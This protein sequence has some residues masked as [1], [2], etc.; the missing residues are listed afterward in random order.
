MFM[1]LWYNKIGEAV[2]EVRALQK[3]T[4]TATE[5]GKI[6]YNEETRQKLDN[7]IKRVLSLKIILAW[8]MIGCIEEYTGMTAEEAAEYI[9][10]EPHVSGVPVHTSAPELVHGL[11]TVDKKS[12]EKTV[13]YD[14]CFT[15]RL[16]GCDDNIGLIIN[17]EAQNDFHPGYPLTK[18]GLYYCARMLSAQF[19]RDFTEGDYGNLKKVYSIWICPHAPD[20]RDNT[21]VRYRIR[22]DALLGSPPEEKKENYDLLS[23]IFICFNDRHMAERAN[24]PLSGN[25]AKDVSRLLGVL[26]S[27]EVESPDKRRIV[28]KEYHMPLTKTVNE[29]VLGMC[30][31]SQGI[32]DAGV[33]KGEMRGEA[34]GRKVGE[35]YGR[36]VG[37]EYGAAKEK[38]KFVLNLLKNGTSLSFIAAMTEMEP[39]QIRAIAKEHNLPVTES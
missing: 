28:E 27:Q 21:I 14:I 16:P 20:N 18:R 6:V 22:E 25:P 7:A 19:N 33:K 37:E 38:S 29:E 12:G 36:K 5:V 4:E 15:A 1:I 3:E 26:L 2:L 34:R 30:N 31:L 35:E 23:L 8:I 13:L 10:G 32:Y 9:E 39:E 11:D 17:I 24:E